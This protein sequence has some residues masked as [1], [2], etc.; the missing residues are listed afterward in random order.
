[1]A[2]SFSSPKVQRLPQWHTDEDDGLMARAELV[3][4]FGDVV[5]IVLGEVASMLGSMLV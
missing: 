2:S 1:M 4:L 5:H 3:D